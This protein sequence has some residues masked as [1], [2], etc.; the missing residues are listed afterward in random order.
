MVHEPNTFGEEESTYKL[1]KEN[2]T[3]WEPGVYHCVLLVDTDKG[4][5][6]LDN[7]YVWPMTPKSLPYKWDKALREDGNG[8]SYRFSFV[9]VSLC[10]KYR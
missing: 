1:I 5:Y 6:I 9:V 3:A 10:V 8:T 2:T 4:F 7:R